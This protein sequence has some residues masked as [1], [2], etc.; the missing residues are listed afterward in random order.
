MPMPS[1]RPDGHD[2]SKAFQRPS[3]FSVRQHGHQTSDLSL[4][5]PDG[6]G[7]RVVDKR[8][9]NRK[10]TH[11]LPLLPWLLRRSWMDLAFLLFDVDNTTLVRGKKGGDPVFRVQQSNSP[12]AALA[13]HRRTLRLGIAIQR[14]RAP[15]IC[16][17]CGRSRVDRLPAVTASSFFPLQMLVRPC[18]VH[19]V[20]FRA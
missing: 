13:H 10:T 18:T 8:P 1:R 17:R 5:A 4:S 12:A 16:V 15:S 20:A 7:Y 3:R 9:T 11:P 2:R 19:K 6:E 14:S